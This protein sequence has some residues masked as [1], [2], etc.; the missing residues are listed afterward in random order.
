MDPNPSKQK[1]SDRKL[2]PYTD[3]LLRKKV[4]PF[5]AVAQKDFY[6]V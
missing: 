3:P 1:L 6:F 5:M 4:S 2:G